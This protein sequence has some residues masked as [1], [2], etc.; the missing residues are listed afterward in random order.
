MV[1][2]FRFQKLAFGVSYNI[3]IFCEHQ[4]NLSVH[5]I[6][7]LSHTNHFEK[8]VTLASC[9]IEPTPKFWLKRNRDDSPFTYMEPCQRFFCQSL[10][11]HQEPPWK[12]IPRCL[13]IEVETPI[14]T[15]G[16]LHKD[17][18]ST[19]HKLLNCYLKIPKLPPELSRRFVEFSA[20]AFGMN[21]LPHLHLVRF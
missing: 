13:E 7:I 4:F 12:E 16:S 17:F 14:T 8:T 9:N 18:S 2:E 11:H 10:L 15:Q 6:K 5:A 21:F 1:W 3:Q 20:D 19:H